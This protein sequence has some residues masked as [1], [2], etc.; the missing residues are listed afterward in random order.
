MFD[1]VNVP[2]LGVVENMSW[3]EL[4]DGGRDYL[5]GQKGGERFAKARGLAFLGSVPINRSVGEGGD[6]G[7]PAVIGTPDSSAAVALKSVSMEVA[8]QISISNAS[9][10]SSCCC[11]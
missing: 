11:S 9:S 4:P 3:Y 1:K 10:S 5:F 6:N 2:I 8:R 7:T